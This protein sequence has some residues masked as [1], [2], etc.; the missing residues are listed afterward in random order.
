MGAEVEERPDR[1]ADSR[2]QHLHGADWIRSESRIAMAFAVAA[3]L[4][5]RDDNLR[6]DAA[7]VS[8]P[9]FFEGIWKESA[10]R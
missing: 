8:Y 4:E 7:G 3:L 10:G 1:N 6:A 2:G 5:V 9:T